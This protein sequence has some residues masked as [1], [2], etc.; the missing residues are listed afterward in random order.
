[1]ICSSCGKPKNSLLTKKSRLLNINLVMCQ[2]CAKAKLEPRWVIILAA[3]Q[4]G[5]DAVSDYITKHRYLGDE[6]K[7]S[8]IVT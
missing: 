8:D 5:V 6:I 2:M 1:M 4:D 7:A 3:R